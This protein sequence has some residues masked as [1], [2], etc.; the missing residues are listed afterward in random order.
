MIIMRRPHTP[1]RAQTLPQRSQFTLAA[2][3]ILL[4]EWTT[5]R[6]F[7]DATPPKQSQNQPNVAQTSH[8]LRPLPPAAGDYPPINTHDSARRGGS[9]L[10]S[11]PSWIRRT[12]R[13]QSP[14][15]RTDL[16]DVAGLCHFLPFFSKIRPE[17]AWCNVG[18]RSHTV[19]RTK[20][21]G[22]YDPRYSIK[23][24]HSLGL[25]SLDIIDILQ[26]PI[27]QKSCALVIFYKHLRHKS[28]WV[29]PVYVISPFKI[30][31]NVI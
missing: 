14:K 21:I 13:K 1:G 5:Y 30:A 22:E 29:L 9:D 17:P 16:V 15:I 10:F 12:D 28:S 24:R 27:A 6:G 11:S 2:V 26:F 20:V 4:T 25:T 23:L 3:E 8:F 18:V 31:F 19:C 7:Y